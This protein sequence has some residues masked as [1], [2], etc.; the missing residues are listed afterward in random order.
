MKLN[1]IIIFFFFIANIVYSQDT[2]V[3]KDGLKIACKYIA[4]DGTSVKYIT[5]INGKADTIEILKSEIEKIKFPQIKYV[6]PIIPRIETLTLGFGLGMDMGGV[7]ATVSIS[8]H[9]NICLIGGAGVQLNGLCWNAGMKIRTIAM[10]KG[11]D[12]L[13]YFIAL[14]GVNTVYSV[15]G[16]PSLNK[17]FNG[18]SAGIGVDIMANAKNH[19]YWSFAVIYP[20]R[21]KETVAYRTT[22]VASG[23]DWFYN[24]PLP[25]T[26][27]VSYRF[28]IW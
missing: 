28:M 18:L 17:T 21:S 1:L 25:I 11:E 27:S 26:I 13:P 5:F 19:N 15:I 4:D 9:K 23:N 14:Y 8:P 7:G 22:L 20:I 10:Q 2:I 24:K 12:V 3:K 16:N 6:E